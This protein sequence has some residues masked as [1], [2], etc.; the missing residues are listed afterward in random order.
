MGTTEP[1]SHLAQDIA[2]DLVDAGLLRADD[3][4]AATQVVA[5]R[6]PP[7][8]RRTDRPATS[9]LAAE[10][11]GYLGGILVVAAAAVFIASQWSRM[12]PG[13]RVA[14]LLVSALVLAGAALAVRRTAPAEHEATPLA[15]HARLLLAGTL[16]VGA[17]AVAAGAVGTW[18]LQVAELEEPR[19]QQLGFGVACLLMT[20]V[21]ALTR[22]AVA[23]LGIAIT[24]PLT[25][26]TLVL[27]QDPPRR[28]AL[29]VA[30]MILA[31]GVVWLALTERG[32][33][34]ERTLGQV[35]GG[36]LS[37]IGAQTAIADDQSWIAY[38]LLAVVGAAAFALYSR[39]LDWPYLG[40]GVVALTLAATEAAVDLSDGALGAAGAL[41]VAGAVLLG[42]SVL[43]LRLRTRDGADPAR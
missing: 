27:T 23:H 14:A 2:G 30:V 26:L 8:A 4:A 5:A 16:G 1:S 17:A 25:L 13:T 32:V 35:V 37:V 24:A 42:A 43:G 34:R 39:T 31:L 22:T 20:V 36:V 12:G 41:L 38:V 29:V 15:R 33:L 21:Y 10:V 7:D 6:V 3:R 19:P 9:R 11:A 28:A 40:T 18:G